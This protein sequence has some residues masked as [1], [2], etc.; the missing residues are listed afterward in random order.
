MWIQMDEAL[1]AQSSIAARRLNLRH[2]IVIE[3]GRK[4]GEKSRK[5]R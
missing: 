2:A 1:A 4:F 3:S 5:L